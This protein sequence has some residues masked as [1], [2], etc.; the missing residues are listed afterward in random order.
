MPLMNLS[1]LT[2]DNAKYLNTSNL[3]ALD[4]FANR[5]MKLIDLSGAFVK[6]GPNELSVE[7]RHLGNICVK[8]IS[9]AKNF[10]IYI[11]KL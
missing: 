11:E 5:V 3:F 2:F 7:F 4:C 9:L 8:N 6:T 10:T 1:V